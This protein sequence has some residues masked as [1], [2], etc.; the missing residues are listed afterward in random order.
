M[1]EVL[2]EFPKDF[3]VKLGDQTQFEG[4][5]TVN[6]HHR[7]GSIFYQVEVNIVQREAQKIYSHVG[8]FAEADEQEV[9]QRGLR[10]LRKFFERGAF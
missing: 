1:T 3:F 2:P 7:E 6:Y 5:L 9:L 8:I 10:E 4:K